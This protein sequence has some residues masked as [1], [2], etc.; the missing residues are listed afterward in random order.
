MSILAILADFASL[1]GLAVAAIYTLYKVNR[2]PGE[3][4]R[5]SRLRILAELIQKL[6]VTAVGNRN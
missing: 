5:H 4:Q 3:L 1:A 2:L 6:E